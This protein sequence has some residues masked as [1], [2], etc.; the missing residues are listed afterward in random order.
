MIP[1]V[2]P[3]A[4]RLAL[5]LRREIA[6]L[7]LREEDPFA[8][9]HPLFAACLPLSRLEIEVLDRIP[10]K[11]TPIVLYDDGEGLVAPAAERLRR[12]GYTCLRAL[13]GGLDGWRKAGFELFQD[14]NSYSKAFGELVD[15]RRGKSLI[16]SVDA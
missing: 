16:F 12:L 14:V 1:T 8:K 10:R 5:L 4:V 3:A 6:L 7:D 15:S 11:D 9:N 13:E 2:S